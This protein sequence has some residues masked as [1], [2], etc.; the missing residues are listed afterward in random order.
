VLNRSFY[1]FIIILSFA[2]SENRSNKFFVCNEQLN[3]CTK[4]SNVQYCTF[5]YKWGEQ[6]PYSPSGSGIPGPAVKSLSISY[7]FQDEGLAFSTHSQENVSSLSF[8]ESDKSEIRLAFLEWQAKANISFVEK[9]STEKSN[10]TV[11]LAAIQQGGIGYPALLG[12]PCGQIA[13]YLILNSKNA[14]RSKL[15]LHEIGHTLGLGHVT[16]NNVMNPDKLYD[17]LQPGD[18]LGITSI[19]GGK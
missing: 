15:A 10:I 17:R 16:S 1:I 6:N 8:N 4:V 3:S 11:I 18:S 5:G 7:K 9:A 2:C 13:G 12:E 19:Y 14:S